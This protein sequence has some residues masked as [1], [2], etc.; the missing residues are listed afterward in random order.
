MKVSTKLIDIKVGE[1]FKI[2]KWIYEVTSVKTFGVN[3]YY[4]N[5]T[6]IRLHEIHD[7]HNCFY[8]GDED[9]L[10]HHQS[11]CSEQLKLEI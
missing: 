1:F 4:K 3:K 6:E 7:N 10:L 8:A 2:G 5:Y 9:T 11:E